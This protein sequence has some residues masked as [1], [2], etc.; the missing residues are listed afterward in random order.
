MVYFLSDNTLRSWNQTKK[1]DTLYTT[2]YDLS[3][4]D[5]RTV[6]TSKAGSDPQQDVYTSRR[7]EQIS[8]FQLHPSKEG[9]V[10]LISD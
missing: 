5:T 9:V 10:A 3:N 4:I 6:K 7:I 1:T 2:T 8:Y